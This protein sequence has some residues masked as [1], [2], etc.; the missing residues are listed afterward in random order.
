MFATVWKTSVLFAA[1]SAALLAFMPHSC[2]QETRRSL[3]QRVTQ[4]EKLVEK[5]QQSIA[6]LES[7]MAAAPTKA[8]QADHPKDWRDKRAWRRLRRGMTADDVTSLLG[9]PEKVVSLT[10]LTVWYWDYPSGPKVE[11]NEKSV[12]I[13]WSEP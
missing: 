4:L 2:A 10:H 6:D 12:V 5:L 7:K 3:E 8:P 13:G 9:E 1:T 11:L